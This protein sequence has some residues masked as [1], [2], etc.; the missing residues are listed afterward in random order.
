[1]DLKEKLRNMINGLEDLFLNN[2]ACICCRKEIPDGTN[3]FSL[4]DK[5]LSEISKISGSSCK[6]C[7]EEVDINVSFCGN[8]NKDKYYFD[9]NTSFAN[10]ELVAAKIV[11][12]FKFYSKKYYAKYIAKLMV[13]NNDVFKD[14]DYL[15]FVPISDKR[16]KERGF[17]QAEE[18]ANEISKLKNIPVLDLLNKIG[19]EKHQVGLSQKE[20]LEN[21]KG[22]FELIKDNSKFIKGKNLLIIDD[23]FTT[24]STLSECARVIK[25]DK[26]N[27]PKSVCSYTFAKTKLF[28]TN[29]G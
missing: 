5:C 3:N 15:T 18:I 27:K 26:I 29:N 23:V 20:R 14:V 17:N 25:S 8:C 2:H 21:L 4:C 19:D 10:Y 7:G 13:E 6:I 24:G 16:R 28:S 1:M 11:K 9:K 22:S 12:R